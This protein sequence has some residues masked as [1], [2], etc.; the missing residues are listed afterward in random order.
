ML[1]IRDRALVGTHDTVGRAYLCLDG[2]GY[3]GE[4]LGASEYGRREG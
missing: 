4:N 2:L 3:P 1:S